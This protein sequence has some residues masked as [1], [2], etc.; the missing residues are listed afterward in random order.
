MIPAFFL[1]AIIGWFRARRFGGNRLDQMQYAFAHGMA[2]FLL[3]LL[4]KSS[5]IGRV[6]FR[7]KKLCIV[8]LDRNPHI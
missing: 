6:G 3:V 8:V 1:G 7:P 5:L 4:V 2:L